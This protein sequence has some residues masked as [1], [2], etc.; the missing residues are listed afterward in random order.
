MKYMAGIFGWIIFGMT[1][2]EVIF[3][4][5]LDTIGC[6]KVELNYWGLLTIIWR[7]SCHDYQHDDTDDCKKVIDSSKYLRNVSD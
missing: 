5:R 3:G 6:G 2:N 4:T 7:H 1:A